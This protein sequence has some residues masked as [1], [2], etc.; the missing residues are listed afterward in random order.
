MTSILTNSNITHVSMVLR[1]PKN[2]GVD[3]PD[4]L[5]LMETNL[6]KNKFFRTTIIPFY[7][8]YNRYSSKIYIEKITF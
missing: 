5:Y 6:Y 4:G 8:K 2:I 1:N 3:M 7:Q